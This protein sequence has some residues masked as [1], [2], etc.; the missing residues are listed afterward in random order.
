MEHH[1]LHFEGGI[2]DF[3]SVMVGGRGDVEMVGKEDGGRDEER[4]DSLNGWRT[5][6][7]N[8]H[9]LRVGITSIFHDE[10]G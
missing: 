10:G 9:Q 5:G 8:M 2:G 4:V 6:H 7:Q 3:R 1:N